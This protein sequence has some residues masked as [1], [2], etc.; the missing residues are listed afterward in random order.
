MEAL[1]D[2][3]KHEAL[4]QHSSA[5]PDWGTPMI[6]RRF[7]ACV[8]RP[9]ALG[10]AIDLDYASSAYWHGYWPDARS[11]PMTYLDGSPGRD[12]LVQADRRAVMKTNSCGA[13]YLNAPGLNGGEMVQR[14]WEVFDGDHLSGWLGS[15]VWIGFSLE[16]FAS[17]QGVSTRNPLT[18]GKDDLI[19]TIVPPRRVR[20]LLHPEALI[21]LVKKKQARRERGGKEWLALQRKIEALRGRSDDSPVA[22]DAP[23]HAS[24]LSILWHKERAVRRRQ[25]EAARAFLKAQGDQDR[26]P[27]QNVAI[28]GE[29]AP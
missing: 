27:L 14:C 28:V 10:E 3:N 7:A 21:E 12:V 23:P 25:M 29:M 22:G 6:L 18:V 11:T 8:L 15:G 4:A 26:S 19:T 17:L 16:Q 9:A 13:G 24:Y 2:N 5:S 20:Y 1:D